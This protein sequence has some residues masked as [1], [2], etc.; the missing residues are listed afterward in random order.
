LSHSQAKLNLG[1]RRRG[2]QRKWHKSILV[3]VSGA[4][5]VVMPSCGRERQLTSITIQPA[6][7]T[8]LN[9]NPSSQIQF[10]AI[11]TY[12]HPPDT[13]DIT[14]QVTWKTDSQGIIN[15]VGGLVSP[16]GSGCGIV[17]ISASMDRGTGPH[18]S[19][20]IGYSSVTVNDPNVSE[21]PGGS[22]TKAALIVT[23]AGNGT[24]TVVSSPAG[25][26]CPGQACGAQ[27]TI[28]DSIVLTETPASGSTFASW[29]G[30]TSTSA[31]TCTVTLAGQTNIVATFN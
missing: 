18:N 2:M 8:F 7:A 25:I 31:N 26:S 27:F 6:T 22:S 24:G 30:C 16:T 14:S 10:S 4:A 5:M 17:D 19:L 11:G 3:L 28:G 21:C 9:P 29:T 12:I 13:K 15:V 20:V 23:P 1:F